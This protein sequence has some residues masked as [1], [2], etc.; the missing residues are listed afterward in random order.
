MH[1]FRRLGFLA[2]R[3]QLDRDLRSEMQQ[4]VELLTADLINEGTSP[5]EARRIA[6][7]R[8][9][10]Q[11]SLREESRDWW[12]FPSVESF[13]QDLRF[14]ARLLARSPGFTLVA[15][16]T[17]AL[18]IGANTA[19]F[20]VV[21]SVL[22]RP[23][24][25]PHY[26]RLVNVWRTH[27]QNWIGSLSI[28]DFRDWQQQNTALEGI[29]A[30]TTRRLSLEGPAE[31]QAIEA[32]R[33][34]TNFFD[35]MGTPPAKGRAFLQEEESNGRGNV[36]IL[37]HETWVSDFGSDP[38]IIGRV[39][40]LNREPFTVVGVAASGF[41]YPHA[42][43][44]A[45]VPLVPSMAEERRDSHSFVGIGRLKAGVTR[46]QATAQ[47]NTICTAMAKDHPEDQGLGS[48]LVPLKTAEVGGVEDGL[49]VAFLVVG[50]TFMIACA[51]VATFLLS[52]AAARQREIAIRLAVG[53][54]SSRL[55]VQF[56]AEGLLLAGIAA[57]VAL[58]VSRWSVVAI[59]NVG[60]A[61]FP[62]SRPVTTDYRAAIFTLVLA[63]LAAVLV[64]LV[65]GWSARHISVADA[66]KENAASVAGS[67]RR[68]RG[69][70][71]LVAIQLACAFLLLVGAGTLVESFIKLSRV[72]PGFD[73]HHVL[74]MRVPI[75]SQDDSNSHPL[76]LVENELARVRALPGVIAAGVISFL[77]MQSWGTNTTIR[78]QGAQPPVSREAPWAEVRAVSPGYY[79]ALR[80]RLPRGRG[81]SNADTASA[82]P[83]AVVNETFVKQ[84]SPNQDIIGR[85]ISMT[86][87][88]AWATIVGVMEDSL[89]AGRNQPARAEVDLPYMQAKYAYLT[90]SMT[91]VVRTA[92][93]PLAM[94]KPVQQTIRSVDPHQ[95]VFGTTTVE[96]I[97][98]D[99]EGDRHFALWLLGVFA[100]LAMVLAAAGL[101]AQLSYAVTERTH[102]LGV[103][104]ALGAK[105]SDLLRIVIVQGALVA[106]IGILGGLIASVGLVKVMRSLLFGVNPVQASVLISAALPLMIVALLA[107]FLP[108]RR[109]MAVDPMISL[110]CE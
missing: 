48:Q 93:D 3:E 87:G 42:L 75:S 50:F 103:R 47:L 10:N 6:L 77:P 90:Q 49:L 38:N 24:S 97:I 80:I 15:V 76:L 16:L 99:L 95:A 64:C 70:Q 43:T 63:A 19:V 92:G 33:V 61:F 88:Q 62:A 9:G 40:T 59:T 89:Q 7:R 12:G 69:Q 79:D 72:S 2:Q 86:D 13:I 51:N 68:L 17:L 20:S 57:V 44:N 34:T 81:I 96:Q 104:I 30:Y 11:R 65:V 22:L 1:L 73:P 106:G 23:F 56:F 29:A 94:A 58:L 18:G 105:R 32:A 83:V 54:K 53:A 4:H 107:S 102:E 84:Y 27:D 35:V 85:Q 66:L 67:R 78:F 55:A 14:G 108:A 109:A 28:P 39:I 21:N 71:A 52:R 91:F 60:H 31:P 41:H 5:E 26:E 101:F 82:P 46:E 37:S 74:A 8:F 98:S 45:W 36:V 110:R 100:G 25:Y